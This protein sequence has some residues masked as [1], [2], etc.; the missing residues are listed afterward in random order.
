MRKQAVTCAL[1]LHF[2]I[3][4]QGCATRVPATDSRPMTAA[5]IPG[6]NPALDHYIAW[7]PRNKALT[8]AVAMA[9]THISMGYA[10]EQA[11]RRLCGDSWLLDEAVTD[12]IGPV[13]VTA[14][15]AMGN[16]PAW[17][18]RVSLQPGLHGCEQISPPQ[19][20]RAI[21]D[22]LP[23]WIRLEMAASAKAGAAR[24]FE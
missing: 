8:P 4:L 21:N 11:A 3:S 2:L 24:W 16:Y 7:V 5:D 13:A 22:N 10:K 18:Y 1:M 12:R 15:A 20:Y 6:M 23:A 9:Q 14:P 17:Y 19:L